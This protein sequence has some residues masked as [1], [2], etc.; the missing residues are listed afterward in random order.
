MK[1]HAVKTK[2]FLLTSSCADIHYISWDSAAGYQSQ[3]REVTGLPSMLWYNDR[4]HVADG[5]FCAKRRLFFKS[6]T[7]PEQSVTAQNGICETI[8]CRLLGLHSTYTRCHIAVANA[9]IYWGCRVA[10]ARFSLVGDPLTDSVAVGRVGVLQLTTNWSQV[11]C[12]NSLK[13][14]LTTLALLAVAEPRCKSRAR[15]SVLMK[16]L[17][18]D[19]EQSLVDDSTLHWCIFL[20]TLL[21]SLHR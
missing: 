11:F 2:A 5:L 14:E 9:A 6:C 16:P 3:S 1:S 10:T 21:Y 19:T 20:G 15:A 13:F 17:E 7:P 4:T 8:T 18:N 12:Y